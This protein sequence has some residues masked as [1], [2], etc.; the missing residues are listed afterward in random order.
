MGTGPATLRQQTRAF[1]GLDVVMPSDATTAAGHQ[2][3]WRMIDELKRELSDAH[4][5]EAATAEVLKVISSSPTD[6]KPVFDAIVRTAVRSLGCDMAVLLTCDGATFSPAVG[7]TSDGRLMDMGPSRLPID[8][9]A[10]FPSRAIV[11]KQMLHI[12]DWSIIDLPEHERNIRNVLGLNSA[13]FLPL[14]HKQECIGVLVLAGKRAN[15]F[16]DNEIALASSFRDQAVIAI[17]NTR[18][19]EAEQASKRELQES[20]EYQTATSEVLNVIS[21]SPSDLQPVLAALLKS[22]SR[23][24]NA[25]DVAI[26]R[27]EGDLLRNVAHHGPMAAPTGYVVPAVR[28][29]TGGRCV[30]ERRPIH[31]ADL[32]AETDE[33]PEGSA[34]AR[35]LDV[36]T[37]VSVPLLREGSPLG[38]IVL[39]RREARPFSDKQVELI[40]TFADQAVIAIENT[41]LFEEVQARNR[42]LTALREVG[43]T[44][45]STLDLK[46]VLKTIVDRAVELSSTDAGSIFYYRKELGRF[47]LG[48]TSGLDDEVVAR[49]RELDI[50]EDQTGLGEAIANGQPL[51]APDLEERPSNPLRDAALAAGLHAGLIVPLLGSEGPL[52]RLVLQRRR[53]GEFLSAV[54]N[55]MQSFA[56]Q[57]AIA[58]ENARLFEEIAQ[59]SRELEIASQHKSQF[60]ANMSHELRTPLAAVLGYAELLQE[61]FY[62]AQGPKSLDALTRIRS[63]G[64]HL[65][66]LINTVLD[67]AK[68][69]S[70]QFTLNMAEYAIESV[71]ETVRSATESLAQNKRLTL[72][73]EVAKSLPIGLGDEQRLTQVLLNLVGNAIKFTDTGDVRVSA[74]AANGTFAV[75]VADTGPGIPPDQ[76]T[77][78]FEQFHQVD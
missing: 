70:G 41:R 40:T 68:I 67:I 25:D 71:V 19:F 45:S 24:C 32:Q 53:T 7:A 55:L 12:P 77:R 59:K 52:G 37:I 5:R 61:G 9:S 30:L 75:S 20:L 72:K 28:G 48:E 74:V 62:E 69:E 66:G 18:L 27:L 47:E 6:V 21:R 31:V 56:D 15:A 43:R 63:N 39:R 57:S 76:L 29:T 49:F 35:E 26:M 38:T 17:E 46:M 2:D 3:L 14:L 73:T 1:K 64:Q 22:A 51:Q 33:Y 50:A 42:D 54:V 58:L 11:G 36:R 44:V 60:V 65:L 16:G 10:N 8:P 78:V 34:Q 4:R 13:I 23:F